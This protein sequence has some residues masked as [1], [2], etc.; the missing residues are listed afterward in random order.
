MEIG[1]VLLILMQTKVE[2]SSRLFRTDAW[3]IWIASKGDDEET[4][5]QQAR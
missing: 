5:S 3:A 4:R 1:A 2:H